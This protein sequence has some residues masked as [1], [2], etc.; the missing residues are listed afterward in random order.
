MVGDYGIQNDLSLFLP[1]VENITPHEFHLPEGVLRRFPTFW[2][3]DAEMLRPRPSFSFAD[4]KYHVP[5][6]KILNFHPI[7]VALN[8]NSLGAYQELKATQDISQV[9][10][11]DLASYTNHS[12]PGDGTFFRELAGHIGSGAAG[13]NFTVSELADHWLSV[14]LETDEPPQGR[15]GP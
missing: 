15:R 2:E 9:S 14:R 1:D 6:M 10:L 5:G 8:A 12:E 11:T 7:L 13:E 4:A 3:D